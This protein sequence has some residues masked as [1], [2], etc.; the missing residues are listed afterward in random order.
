MFN[1]WIHCLEIGEKSFEKYNPED[2]QWKLKNAE[3]NLGY[4]DLEGHK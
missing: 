1:S 2:Q 4:I 3:F